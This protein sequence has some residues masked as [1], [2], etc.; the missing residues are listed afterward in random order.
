[1]DEN[2]KGLLDWKSKTK[3]ALNKIK[4]RPPLE[5][6]ILKIYYLDILREERIH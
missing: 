6:K 2:L 5:A 1:M 4:S 3:D